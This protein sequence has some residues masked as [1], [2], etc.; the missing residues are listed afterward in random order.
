MRKL[1]SCAGSWATC[2]VDRELRDGILDLL[3]DGADAA[4]VPV[5]IVS[6]ALSG[7]VHLDFLEE[8]GLTARFA[9]EIHSDAAGC[10]S[11]TRR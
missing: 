5:G 9:V 10:A 7:Q 4:R 11:P 2:G 6:N 8:H 1:P 3:L